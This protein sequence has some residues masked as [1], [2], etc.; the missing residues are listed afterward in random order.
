MNA[1]KDGSDT[2][3]GIALMTFAMLI[4]P[5]MDAIA[6]L[7]STGMSA[8]E[9]S[10]GRFTIQTLL[11]G[12]I[13]LI[14]G[15]FS[16][17]GQ[18][19]RYFALSGFFISTAI[20]FMFWSLKYLPIANAIAI[21]FI[22]PLVLTVISAFFLKEKV[23]WRRIG[24]VIVGL[25]GALIVIRPNWSAFGWVAVLPMAAA[26]FFASYLAVTRHLTTRYGGM[27]IQMWSGFFASVLLVLA[28][29]VG[30]LFEAEQM[31]L[32]V[33]DARELFLL[34]GLGVLSSFSHLIVAMAFKRTAASILAPFQYLEIISATALGYFI[35]GDFPDS[36]TWFGTAII[37]SSGLY[38]FY[39]ERRLGRAS[40]RPTT[41]RPVVSP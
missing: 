24:A 38:V 1:G 33:P 32:T 41:S 13:V 17:P 16:N 29:G 40:R 8:G 19:I 12:G 26:F 28:L 5:G 7:L 10:F 21:F 36:M 22:E 37:I 27:V 34:V 23:G 25:A 4:A 15:R 30:H 3:K 11:L 6:K 2:E 18:D 39:R 9:V 20:V 14:S 31:A 35:F